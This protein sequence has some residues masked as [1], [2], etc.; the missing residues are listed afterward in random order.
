[1]RAGLLEKR[2]TYSLASA[3]DDLFYCSDDRFV[4][5]YLEGLRQAG[6]PA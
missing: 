5:R 1:M 2:P 6:V 4:D 3:R